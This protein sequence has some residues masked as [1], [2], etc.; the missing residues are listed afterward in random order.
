MDLDGTLS[1][2]GERSPYD[3]Q[4][5]GED[6]PNVPVVDTV[7]ALAVSGISIV[8]VSG[9]DECCRDLSQEW[10]D[11]KLGLEIPLYMRA[12]RDG[13]HDYQVKEEIYF[14]EILPTWDVQFAIDDRQQCVDL[15]RSLGI[16]TFQVAPGDF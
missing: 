9:R 11:D 7:K 6:Q 12:S 3:W 1:L 14:A 4:R 10:I 16:T 5:V 8:V 15:W 2:R 13:R